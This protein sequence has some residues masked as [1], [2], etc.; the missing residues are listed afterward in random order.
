VQA[1]AEPQVSVRLPAL[2][3]LAARV[4]VGAPRRRSPRPLR[5][6]VLAAI[7][8]VAAASTLVFAAPLAYAVRQ[9][10]RGAELTALQRDAVRIAALVPE[11]AARQAQR[12]PRPAGLSAEIS[13]GLY[14]AN[15]SLLTGAGPRRSALAAAARDGKP[16]ADLVGH[17]VTATAPVPSDGAITSVVLVDTSDDDIVAHTVRA[18]VAMAVLA[19]VVLAA[20]AVVARAQASRLVRPLEQLAA[21]ARALGSGDFT[22][23]STRSGIAEA[24]SASAALEQTALRLGRVRERERSFARDVSHQLRTP[25]AALL[26]GLEGALA[27]PDADLRAAAERAV[28]RAQRLQG[29]IDDLLTLTAPAVDDVRCDAAEEVRDAVAR[30]HGPYADGGRRVVATGVPDAVEIA[31]PKAAL[32]QILDVLL[33][34]ALRHG[35]GAA[36]VTVGDVPGGVAVD[37]ADEGA[38]VPADGPQRRGIG[39]DLAHTL[40]ASS[41]ARLVVARAVPPVFRLLVPRAGDA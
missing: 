12:L 40:A 34:N 26:L 38:G 16:H 19:A 41:G 1:Q 4:R 25:L 6:R 14:R 24:D 5:R 35:A 8:L 39:L 29:T 15:G 23:R 2:R 11:S 28:E 9:I 18:W 22:V 21:S 13:I 33:D 7:L 27:R 32:R 17:Q 36:T 37:V 20:A 10:Y 31:M 30:W 3:R